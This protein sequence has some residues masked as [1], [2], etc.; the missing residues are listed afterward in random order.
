[1][2]SMRFIL[3]ALGMLSLTTSAAHAETL[4]V[5]GDHPTIAA[6]LAAAAPGDQIDVA[7]GR[8]CGAAVTKRV[9]LVGHPGATIVGCSES[10]LVSGLRVG[11]LLD[12]RP[13][14]TPADDTRISGFVFDGA[15]LTARHREA[16]AFG[17]FGRFTSGVIV[18]NNAFLR[19]VQAVTNTAGDGWV[20]TSNR[21]RGLTAMSGGGVGIV[22]QS[23]DGAIAA[24]GGALNPRNRPEDN[25]VADNDV[26]GRI[27]DRLDGYS[28]AA[29]LVVAADRTVVSRNHVRLP[30]NPR[31]HAAGEGVLVTS[32]TA[33]LSDAHAP[34]ARETVVEENDG[35][36]CEIGVLVEHPGVP[37]DAGLEL[38]G[39]RGGVVVQERPEATPA[40]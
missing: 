38:R 31:G 28:M 34:G 21:V 35:L 3:A 15:G 33:S 40:R 7:S 6:A 19:M 36:G 10:P 8:H 29:I 20:I 12:G 24:L 22:V 17:V 26:E 5:P 14:A 13:G 30:A 39:N 16:L 11:F 32:R 18:S 9:A 4:H 27:P 23:A 37:N 2:I 1:M 25:T